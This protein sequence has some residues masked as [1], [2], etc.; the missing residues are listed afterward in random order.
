MSLLHR[1]SAPVLTAL[2][3]APGL[4]AAPAAAAPASAAPA[5]A[6]RINEIESDAGNGVRDWVELVNAGPD[7]V[8]A[9]GATV[10]DDDDTH[11]V[12]LAAGTVVQPG[13]S[14]VVETPFDL[15]AADTARLLAADR[16]TLDSYTWTSAAPVTYARCA[17][18]TGAFTA[19]R[20]ATRGA[21]NACDPT[22]AV[23]PWPGG[24]AVTPVDPSGVLGGNVSGLVHEATGDPG[25]LWAVRNSPSVLYRLQ[26]TGNE[27]A[28]AAGDWAN[29]KALKFP[30]GG[31]A[32]DAEGVALTDAGAAGGLF[33][34][35]ERDGS[36]ATSRP[37]I[38]RYRP[39]TAGT[40]LSA[41]GSWDLT[42]DLPAVGSN[43]GIESI[44]WVPDAFVTAGGLVDQST[45]SAY[46]PS[47]YAGHGDG[48]FLV[49]LEANGVVY[50]YALDLTGAGFTR[51][52]TFTSGFTTV[53]DLTWDRETRTVW[54]ECDNGCQGRTARLDVSGGAFAVTQVFERPTGMANLNNEGFAITPQSQCRG[55]VKPVF[56]ADDGNTGGNAI[57]QGTLACTPLPVCDDRQA[58]V[59]GYGAI[60]GTAGDDVIVGSLG[61][62]TISAGGGDDVVCSLGGNDVVDGGADDDTLVGDVGNDTL[63]GAEGVDVVLGGAGNDVLGEGPAANG[64]DTLDGGLG[65]DTVDYSARTAAVAVDVDATADDGAVGEGDDVVAVETLAGGA[66]GDSL[67]GGDGADQLLGNGGADRLTGGSGADVVRGGAGAD[68]LVEGP[69]ANGADVLDGGTDSDTVDYS[70]RTAAVAVSRNGL[71]DDGAAGEADNAVVERVLGGAGADTLVG[72]DTADV[73]VGGG[74]ADRLDGGRGVDVLHGGPGNDVLVEGAVAN[75]ADVLDGGADVD[76]VD[77]SA[78]TAAVTVRLDAVAGDG[79]ANERDDVRAVETVLGG[80][81]ADTLVGGAGPETLQGG[82]GRDVLDGAG[83]NDVLLGGDDAD[84][85]TG[86]TGSDTLRGDAG[87]DALFARDGVAGNDRLNG[88]SGV[89][90]ASTDPDDFV[91]N[92]P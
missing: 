3:L 11:P 17:D 65:T 84:S 91:V 41:D 79:G 70:A 67:T 14:L 12:T 85:V 63:R 56:W 33:V 86:G 23:G 60:S 21:A 9:G 69:A 18:R 43:A 50:A 64:A 87:D 92:V 62:D 81:G 35:S 89:D 22:P 36:S 1:V 77:Y 71:A 54:A 73:L 16:S 24:S 53:Q 55:G 68:T 2:L 52:A 39:E 29:G 28:P 46:D 42:A 78:R 82:A 25:T 37:E 75:G 80:S 38:L 6:L 30:N 59:T 32:P 58:T 72:G 45:G 26:R 61:P 83:G 74:G 27:W 48:L 15:G 34:A 40:T 8:S 76:T 4:T 10:R 90:T 66:G 51:V 44:A 47:R 7:A 5:S 31:G 88:G 19:V 20:T 49:G 57:R 13:A